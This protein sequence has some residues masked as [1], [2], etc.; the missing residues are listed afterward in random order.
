LPGHPVLE[1]NGVY[2]SA[3]LDPSRPAPLLVALHGF[4][5]S[6]GGI[7]GRLRSCADQYGW[8]VLAPTMAYRDYFDPSQLRSDAQENL[9]AVHALIDELRSGVSGFALQSKL[10][11]YGF[12][13]G[14]QM[15]DR[16]SV[17]YP[18]EVAGVATLSAGSYTLPETEDATHRPLLFPFGISDLNAIATA[19]FDQAAFSRIPFWVGVG[20]N[21]TNPADTSRAWDTYEG[22]T[23]VERAQAFATQVQG[24]GGS[25]ELHVF[26]G[27][28]HE[29]TGSMRLSAC[30]FL[31]R[32]SA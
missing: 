23:R 24:Q 1:A 8:L 7:A 13:R 29:E 2:L 21:D 5:G 11:L 17:L 20:G 27:A 19:P 30:A 25:V 26:G 16:F 4:S 9:P 32:Q 31:A 6:G 14:A 22:Q 28:G 3:N 18:A 12:S 15:A 10:L